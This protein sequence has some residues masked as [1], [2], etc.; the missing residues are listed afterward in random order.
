MSLMLHAHAAI[1]KKGGHLT[2]KGPQSNMSVKILSLRGSP[3]A[4]NFL[5]FPSVKD[6]KREL[7]VAQRQAADQGIKRAVLQ[8]Q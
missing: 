7:E 6:T 4:L 3:S 2:T 1:W 8:R 5:V